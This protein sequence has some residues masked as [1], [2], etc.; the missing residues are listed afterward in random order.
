MRGAIWHWLLYP[1]WGIARAILLRLW[2]LGLRLLGFKG[3]I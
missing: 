1:L 2:F 3:R